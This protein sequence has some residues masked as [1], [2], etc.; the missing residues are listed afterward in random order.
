[1]PYSHHLEVRF[2]DCDPMGHVNNAVYLT[3]LEQARFAHWRA[4]WNYRQPGSNPKV[5]GVILARAEVDY[6]AQAKEGDA[7]EVRLTVGKIG[8]TSFQYDYEILDATGRVVISAK[9]VQVMFD[10]AANRPVPI[11]DE[12][13]AMLTGSEGA[14]AES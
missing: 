6:R 3:Y 5:P 1:M 9:T 12:I 11:D 13:R 7:L 4:L 2:R 10:Y 8:R 14:G